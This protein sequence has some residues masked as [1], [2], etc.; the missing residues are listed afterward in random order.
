MDYMPFTK[1]FFE[2]NGMTFTNSFIATPICCPSRTE[3]I[4]GRGFHNIRQPPVDCMDIS[5]TFNVFN[6]T[7]SMFQVFHRNGYDTSSFGKL[8]NNMIQYFCVHSPPFTNGFDR[9]HCP[10]D[11]NNFYGAKYM[12]YYPNGTLTVDSN[13][14]LT[15]H[16]YET[17]M[18]GNASIQYLSQIIVDPKHNRP[19]MTW[20][21]VHAPHYPAD[22]A[23]WYS[24]LYSNETAP[25][26]PNFNVH[27]D[28]HYNFVSSNPELNGTAIEWIDQLWRDRLRS[29]L[30]VDDL[31]RD[32]VELLESHD[33]LKNTYILFSSDHGYHLGTTL[34]A[35]Y[36]KKKGFFSTLHFVTCHH[37]HRTVADPLLKAPNLRNR[38]P[39]SNLYFRSKH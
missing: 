22:P 27:V 3:S 35:F 37:H 20:I 24:H 36:Y 6:N 1:H 32:L 4:T 14:A 7:Q 9:I 26:T 38:Y 30:S 17:A 15:P 34:L 18:V 21:G 13:I 31:V 16:L 28:D 39:N 10:C 12:N 19:F 2:S 5:A 23:S 33:V 25:R 11:Y 29:L 8:T